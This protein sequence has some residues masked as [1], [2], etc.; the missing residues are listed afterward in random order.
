MQTFVY[1]A[2]IRNSGVQLPWSNPP[3][4]ADPASV[5]ATTTTQSSDPP[6]EIVPWFFQTAFP[7]KLIDT[8][9]SGMSQTALTNT[10]SFPWATAVDSVTSGPLF[11][12]FSSAVAVTYGC[13]ARGEVQFS[14]EL[15]LT[16][17]IA[18]PDAAGRLVAGPFLRSTSI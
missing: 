16:Q 13:V 17:C 4:Y 10:A 1:G 11:N 2:V 6:L 14:R 15:S 5:S 7:T 8:F 3:V 18:L 12:N 9:T